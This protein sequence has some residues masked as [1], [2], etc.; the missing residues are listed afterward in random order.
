MFCGSSE[1]ILI[2]G[3]GRAFGERHANM[4]AAV[5]NA[6]SPRASFWLG[7]RG[8]STSGRGIVEAS[9]GNGARD[10]GL[11]LGVSRLQGDR[12]RKNI[13]SYRE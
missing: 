2:A 4:A 13:S 7:Q 10:A 1:M 3:C 8:F 6:S 11:V 9:A 12:M 5:G